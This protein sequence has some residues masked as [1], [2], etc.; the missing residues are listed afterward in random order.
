M[1]VQ[2]VTI[3]F[4]G[5]GSQRPEMGRDFLERFSHSRLVY[6]EGS[7]AL[8]IDL[9]DLCRG[10]DARLG[11]TEFAQPAILATEIAMLAA[12]RAELGL[13]GAAYG[14]HS[15]GEYTALVAAGA[16]PFGDA[17]RL[18]RERGRLMQEAVPAGLG[19]MV[20]VLAP[21][22]D[23]TVVARC[24]LG[25]D[26]AVANHNSPGQIVL[27]GLADHTRLAERRLERALGEGAVRFVELDV[28]APFHSP[29][30]AS[31]E[32]PLRFALESIAR[33]I[34]A[35]AA[36]CV[37]SNFRGGFHLGD[38]KA[39]VA[40]LVGQASGEVRWL[41][42]M[43]ALAALGH[44]IVEVGPGRPLR[45]L[46]KAIGIDVKSVTDVR[47]ALRLPATPKAA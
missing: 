44:P 28:S 2:G 41:G 17:L 34:D 23:R 19:R 14:G 33:R 4:P 47:S 8:G 35:A 31:V 6:E 26:V 32:E 39:V 22:L 46:F 25:L 38:R 36:T 15:L 37:A 1:F 20:A 16:L 45:G 24:L 43:E 5:Q 29:L 13:V 7:D 10:E 3:V 40:A 21:E 18:V 9:V 27:S 11:L 30:M 42:N 12:V